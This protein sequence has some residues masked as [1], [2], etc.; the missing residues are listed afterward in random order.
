MPIGVE[1]DLSD[2]LPFQVSCIQEIR[3][4]DSSI[5]YQC[6]MEI[7]SNKSFDLDNPKMFDSC[8]FMNRYELTNFVDTFKEASNGII[9]Q[10]SEYELKCIQNVIEEYSTRNKVEIAKSKRAYFDEAYEILVDFGTQ[11]FLLESCTFPKEDS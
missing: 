11:I 9:H 10:T 2:S 4:E 7:V 6:I 3:N 1:L 8:I 5:I